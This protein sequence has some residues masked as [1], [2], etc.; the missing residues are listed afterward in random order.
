MQPPCSEGSGREHSSPQAG[1]T[2]DDATPQRQRRNQQGPPRLR[3]TEVTSPELGDTSEGPPDA[4][5]TVTEPDEPQ[6]EGAS[7]PRRMHRRP[8]R[9]RRAPVHLADYVLGILTTSCAAGPPT[10]TAAPACVIASC[11]AA[12]P[13]GPAA[14]AAAEVA[15]AHAITPC[16]AA[17]PTGPAAPAAAEAAPARA[18]A[19][20]AAAPPTDP[21]AP[22][23]AEVAPA[24]AIAPL[25]HVFRCCIYLTL[26]PGIGD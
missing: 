10:G 2:A 13:T 16:T 12:P 24:R 21:A 9:R 20:C 17:P 4:A 1:S 25:H 6:S 15:P 19:P 26:P 14:A 11:A 5:P 22:A 18:I 23:A 7:R 8:E 3:I